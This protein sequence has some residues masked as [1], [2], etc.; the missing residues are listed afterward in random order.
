M[1]HRTLT[2]ADFAQPEGAAAG[3]EVLDQALIARKRRLELEDLFPEAAKKPEPFEEGSTLEVTVPLPGEWPTVDTGLPIGKGTAQFLAGAGKR[4][5][6]VQ[7]RAKQVLNKITAGALYP[8]IQEVIDASPA[9]DK[10]LMETTP[11]MFGYGAPDALLSMGIGAFAN[12]LRGAGVMG[13]LQGAAI[14]VTSNEKNGTLLNT[15]IGVVGGGIGHGLGT[16]LTRLTGKVA[17]ALPELIPDRARALAAKL[18]MELPET[19]WTDAEKRRLYLLAKSKGV[20]ISIGDLDPTSEW[21]QAEN[22]MRPFWSGRSASMQKQ[23]DATRR[24]LTDLRDGLAT[25][26][27]GTENAAIEKGV[28]DR[29]AEVKTKAGNKFQLVADIAG[30]SPNLS[31]IRPTYTEMATKSALA[32]YPSLF[33]EFKNN[34]QIS[35]LLGL[36]EDTGPQAGLII[37]PK[38][39]QPF[40]YPQQL[41]FDDA[42]FLRK[43]LGA[44]YDKLNSQLKSGT[45]PQGIDGEAVKHAASIFSAFN[46]DLDAWGSQPGNKALNDAWK[47]AR[48]YYKDNV[49]SFRDPS[50]LDSKSKL[51]QNIV[52]DNVDVDTL[53]TKALPLRETSVAGDIMSHSTP[54]GQA[55]M[56]SAL[57]RKLVDPSI[58]DDI[59]GLGNVSLLRNVRKGEHVGKDVFTPAELQAIQDARDIADLTRRS[60]EA[61]TTPPA[62]GARTLPFMAGSA[63]LGTAGTAYMALGMLGDSIDPATRILLSTVAA[64]V[65][66]LGAM[67]GA[68]KYTNSAFG[69][70]LHFADPEFKG[71][72]GLIQEAA[73]RGIR[74]SGEPLI[75]LYVNE[76][77]GHR[78]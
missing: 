22:S 73:R 25:V 72:L 18:G 31:P 64:P 19:K 11:A 36:Q 37:N 27:E 24:V 70:N 46:K 58:S 44:W 32:D 3:S 53:A 47:D 8:G 71:A 12:T 45:L 50:L 9:L 7:K 33:D 51:V 26:P 1:A 69:Q 60:A 62:T 28:K 15:G 55:G 30:R 29:L 66:V 20:P 38:N 59:Q 40:K 2:L 77:L 74:G 76:Q 6:D 23:Q 10:A 13:G 67:K 78:P 35:K 21:A 57:I 5:S 34:G 4:F 56:K 75:D 39:M 41:G 52:N 17:H 43:R 61:G 42:Q 14:P 63:A 48:S 68:N 65:G 49:L 54:A 16:G